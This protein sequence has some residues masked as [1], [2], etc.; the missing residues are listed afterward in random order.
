MI[1]KEDKEFAVNGKQK[2]S[3]RRETNAVSG[4][5]VMSVQNQHQKTLHP[6]SHQHKE[7]EVRR[8]KGPEAQ[9]WCFRCV[10]C[11]SVMLWLCVFLLVFTSPRRIGLHPSN[12]RVHAGFPPADLFAKR[13]WFDGALPAPSVNVGFPHK[14][15]FAKPALSDGPSSTSPTIQPK[16]VDNEGSIAFAVAGGRP[17]AVR[18]R[19]CGI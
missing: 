15:L 18:F 11:F 10:S 1:L 2:G 19:L 7:A 12:A 17:E 6:L 16:G 4:T 3:V 8:E 5:T 13:A 14:D 9:T